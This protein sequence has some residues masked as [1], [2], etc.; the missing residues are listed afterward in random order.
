MEKSYIPSN[1]AIKWTNPGSPA[2]HIFNYSSA[3]YNKPASPRNSLEP[4]NRS[5]NKIMKNNPK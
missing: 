5:S 3:K 1:I 4:I 2:I